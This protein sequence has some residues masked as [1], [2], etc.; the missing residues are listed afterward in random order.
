MAQAADT[1]AG[2]K[3]KLLILSDASRK[4]PT[5]TLKKIYEGS[6]RFTVEVCDKVADLKGADFAKFD[7][8]VSDYVGKDRWPA[9]TEKAFLDYIAAGHGFVT[10]YAGN[11][12][13][14]DWKEYANLIGEEGQCS[15]Q[16][17]AA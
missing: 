5:A 9:E 15:A 4:G 8:V 7:A 13:W 6:G 12:A 17:Q 2:A 3:V 14:P 11:Q 1:A 10:Y 16:A